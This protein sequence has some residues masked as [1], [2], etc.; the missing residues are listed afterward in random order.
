ML[1]FL[2]P[3]ISLKQIWAGAHTTILQ[4]GDKCSFLLPAHFLHKTHHIKT[5]S[6]SYTLFYYII[7]FTFSSV[8]KLC[9]PLTTICAN[10]LLHVSKYAPSDPKLSHYLGFFPYNWVHIWHTFLC[11]KYKK[12]IALYTITVCKDIKDYCDTDVTNDLLYQLYV[13]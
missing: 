5:A 9:F 1:I 13:W 6:F 10:I 8:L 3:S 4:F 12:L 2:F 7:S 11:L